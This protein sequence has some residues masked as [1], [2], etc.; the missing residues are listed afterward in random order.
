MRHKE[1]VQF[2]ADS[3]RT[4]IAVIFDQ[5]HAYRKR[6]LPTIE[7]LLAEV[8]QAE[9]GKFRQTASALFPVFLRFRRELEA[10]I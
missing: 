6:E 7:A 9:P 2:P 10:H 3:L 5:H 1:S 8:V 4:L